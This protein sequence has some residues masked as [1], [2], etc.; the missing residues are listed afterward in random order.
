MMHGDMHMCLYNQRDNGVHAWIMEFS[1]KVLLVQ[2]PTG[3]ISCWEFYNLFGKHPPRTVLGSLIPTTFLRW[4]IIGQLLSQSLH[5]SEMTD[6]WIVK[7]ILYELQSELKAEL[8]RPIIY[9]DINPLH[10]MDYNFEASVINLTPFSIFP[11]SSGIASLSNSFSYPVSSPRE[12]A[13]STPSAYRQHI[14]IRKV[15]QVRY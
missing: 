8:L 3:D 6:D 1:L 11:S 9:L 5:P 4:N 12:Y 7:Y 13:F 15:R 2:D 10:I 14:Y